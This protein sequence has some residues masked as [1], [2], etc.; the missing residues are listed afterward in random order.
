MQNSIIQLQER[1]KYLKNFTYLVEIIKLISVT[2]LNKSLRVFYKNNFFFQELGTIFSEIIE[3]KNSLFWE[4]KNSF[5]TKQKEE[6]LFSSK[7]NKKTLWVV[8]HSD[9]GFCSNYNSNLGKIMNQVLKNNDE[10]IVIGSLGINFY[11]K[12]KIRRFFKNSFFDFTKTET[13]VSNLDYFI[14]FLLMTISEKNFEVTKL[15]FNEL[16]VSTFSFKSV[17]RS[18]IPLS[19]STFRLFLSQFVQTKDKFIKNKNNPFFKEVVTF[20]PCFNL[21]MELFKNFFLSCFFQ[22]VFCSTKIAEIFT[23]RMVT[24][25]ALDNLGTLEKKLTREFNIFRKEKITRE[26][27][28]IINAL[29]VVSKNR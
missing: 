21:F 17:I 23:R 8:I 13:F 15:V 24:E 22:K 10:I 11:P 3:K 27:I 1:L 2:K 29:K 6:E 14:K 4:K 5:L 28:E 19:V 20:E 16:K 7:E 9:F 26:M 12:T 18:F 25:N